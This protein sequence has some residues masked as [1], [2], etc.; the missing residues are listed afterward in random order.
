MLTAQE[1]IFKLQEAI[2]LLQD[3]DCLQQAAL[4]DS[5]VSESDHTRIQ[6][7]ISDFEDDIQSIRFAEAQDKDYLDSDAHLGQVE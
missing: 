1:K 5:D 7:L 3:V 2:A 6:D 4:G